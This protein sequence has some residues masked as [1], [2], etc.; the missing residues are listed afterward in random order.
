MKK[1]Y[2]E[3][4]KH[5]GG[6][7]LVELTLVVAIMASLILV[8]TVGRNVLKSS[9]INK[10]YQT[11]NYLKQDMITFKTEFGS[12]PGDIPSSSISTTVYPAFSTIVAGAGTTWHIGATEASG[13]S[14]ITLMS[15]SN[16]AMW[17]INTW[18]ANKVSTPYSA[19][20]FA[21]TSYAAGT[22]QTNFQTQN[23]KDYGIQI[24]DNAIIIGSGN[25]GSY[26]SDTNA[27][28]AANSDAT[29]STSY[30]PEL[31][32]SSSALLTG[33]AAGLYAVPMVAL[34]PTAIRRNAITI[35]DAQKLTIK[36]KQGVQTP[37]NGDLL[38][39]GHHQGIGATVTGKYC[40]NVVRTAALSAA[41]ITTGNAF[42]TTNTSN[43]TYGCNVY[44]VINDN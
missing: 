22:E 31:D 40:T 17:M 10:I 1:V 6:F 37:Y 33:N 20:S 39:S 38:F 19:V 8:V 32:A 30:F 42:A 4:T 28:V 43:R 44:M 3:S 29:F 15:E 14:S 16:A 26:T 21:P 23:L 41:S 27:T 12:F 25:S 18:K 35:E 36:F 13:D 9:Q 24:D 11:M 34:L 2:S 5:R 7:T